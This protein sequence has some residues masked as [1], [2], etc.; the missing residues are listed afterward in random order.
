VVGKVESVH[1]GGVNEGVNI[2]PEDHSSTLGVKFIPRGQ[3]RPKVQT[4]VFK[5]WPQRTS[6][7]Y[8]LCTL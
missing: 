2:P 7:A 4:H 1:I 6:N 3:V 5:N 8:I